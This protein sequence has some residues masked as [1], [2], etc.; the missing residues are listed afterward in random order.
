M[1]NDHKPQPGAGFAWVET[2]AGPALVCRPLERHA[3]H[4]FTTRQWALGSPTL[5]DGGRRAAWRQLAETMGKDEFQ[6]ARLRQVHGVSVVVRRPEPSSPRVAGRVDTANTEPLPEADV[7]VSIDPSVAIAIQTADCTPILIADPVTRA[8]AAAHAGWRGLAEGAPAVAVRALVEH[9]GARAADLVVA[10][11]P[12]IS[13]AR[14]EVGADVRQRFDTSGFD[15]A[16]LARWFP[17]VTRPQHWLFD[18]WEA[19]RDQLVDAGVPP[20]QVHVAA[21]CTATYPDVFCSYRRDGIL[22]GRL[23]AAIAAT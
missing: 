22:A 7:I 20:G 15:P 11:G 23:A 19:A 9:A 10:I 17:S 4:L 13:A 18:G 5:D 1:T 2:Q 3:S 12:A 14:Y 16:H 8:V 21:L 6:L